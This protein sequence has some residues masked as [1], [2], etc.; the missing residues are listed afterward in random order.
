M[1][2]YSCLEQIARISKISLYIGR[3]CTISTLSSEINDCNWF[4]KYKTRENFQLLNHKITKLLNT[5][6][7]NIPC[8]LEPHLLSNINRSLIVF[9]ILSL[10]IPSEDEAGHV[11][12]AI[13]R[14]AIWFV[15]YWLN[16]SRFR[17]YLLV[18]FL[19]FAL[20]CSNHFVYLH[21]PKDTLTHH[22]WYP[23][24]LNCN[25]SYG[26]VLT[27]K[28]KHLVHTEN[29]F[30]ASF[31]IFWIST[32]TSACIEALLFRENMKTYRFWEIMLQL[33]FASFA[34]RWERAWAQPG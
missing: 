17:K 2:V 5:E 27:C 28:L 22:Q 29:S 11:I 13:C 3:N 24:P 21:Y 7:R 15:V 32:T 10:T 14:L 9:N 23:T 18:I 19:H 31:S 8:L 33:P 20:L 16:K 25:C 30:K 12:A 34:K 6:I 1:S 4:F 26:D